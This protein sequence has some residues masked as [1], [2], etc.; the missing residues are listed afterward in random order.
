MAATPTTIFDIRK[1]YTKDI[2]FES[3]KAPGVFLNSSKNPNIDMQ[4]TIARNTLDQEDYYEVVL[5]L[6]VTAQ[7]DDSALFL[8]EIEQAGVFQITGII[9][10][11]LELALEVASPNI[12]LPFA[13]EAISDLVTK[14]GF[15]QLLIAPI[16]FES[17]YQQ[18]KQAQ[19]AADN[20]NTA[21]H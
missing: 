1:I 12:L 14:G 2:S 6:S 20:K 7:I 3:P 5:K 4:I 8:I 15:P 21:K 10:E 19:T 11:N 17:L 13:R 9:D 16:N 18:K